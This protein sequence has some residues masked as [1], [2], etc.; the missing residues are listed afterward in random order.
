ML[1]TLFH[2]QQEYINYFF[3]HL[4][5]GE[6]EEVFRAFAAC[7]GTV[8]FTGVG[9]SGIIAEKL[10]MT[11][12]STGTKAMY[13]PA[14]NALHGDIGVL[15]EKDILV[16]LSKSGGS[17]ELL[18]LLPAV[19]KRGAKTI[20][21]VSNQSSR[22][23][24]EVDQTMYLPLQR[25]LC[26]FDLAP[27]TSA[28][29]QLIFGDVIAVA[30]MKEKKFSLNDY[31]MNHPAGII[32][33]KISLKVED[34]MIKGPHLPICQLEDSLAE[35]LITLS[36]K[37]CGCVLAVDHRRRLRGIFTDGDLRRAIQQKQPN[38]LDHKMGSLITESFLS[39]TPTK[40]AVEAMKVMQQKKGKWV[41]ELPV[42]D[43][44]KLVGLIRMHDIV[45]SGIN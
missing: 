11:L 13:L 16:F 18:Q 41:K 33:K 22:L 29:L 21:F 14:T 5:Y 10:A 26:P 24:H 4:D 42:I 28:I 39:V 35:A 12:I 17:E 19:R 6:A 7:S 37:Q 1:K 44:E 34:I 43:N 25:E 40:M 2:Q 31:A 27:T 23:A 8:L 15:T 38:I 45:Q 3:S 36:D 32:G 30:L 9:K 20:A